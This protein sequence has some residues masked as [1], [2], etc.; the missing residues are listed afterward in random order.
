[1]SSP[2]VVLI[3]I[4]PNAYILTYPEG[5]NYTFVTTTLTMPDYP[6]D[7]NTDMAAKNASVRVLKDRF[8]FIIN[9]GRLYDASLVNSLGVKTFVYIYKIDAGERTRLSSIPTVV[10][11]S[12]NALPPN[13]SILSATV[14]SSLTANF[15]LIRDAPSP[16]NIF[17]FN[18][19]P[20]VIIYTPLFRIPVLIPYAVY[21]K[22]GNQAFKSL[23]APRPNSPI[24]NAPIIQR[25]QV[26]NTI[27]QNSPK[28]TNS[29]IVA[30]SPKVTNSPKVN[31]SPK[32]L[33]SPIKDAL[34]SS[35][36]IVLSKQYKPALDLSN[37]N[38]NS[39]KRPSPK[40]PSPKIS[41]PKISSPKISSPK[42]SSPKRIS[43]KRTSLKKK[44]PSPKKEKSKK[45]R[46]KKK[47]GFYLSY[48]K[49]KIKY[50]EL[51]KKLLDSENK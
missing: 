40:R 43:P 31:N 12:I 30:N 45:H 6:W 44:I 46:N 4:D 14:A 28:V 32:V 35:E 38:L 34:E 8:G 36:S 7:K 3:L 37:S 39:P 41:S 11:S 42:I 23:N 20:N 21:L 1:M 24:P 22:S 19:P 51:R 49:Y 9:R 50:L 17:K 48:I 10:F 2:D 13:L 29:P 5:T 33:R 15:N 25:T 27:K 16:A 47:G 18:Y 26:E